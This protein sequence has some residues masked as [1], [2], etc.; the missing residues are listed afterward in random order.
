MSSSVVDIR[1]RLRTLEAEAKVCKNDRL[2]LSLSLGK[3]ETQLN[4]IAA[5]MKFGVALMGLAATAAP[6]IAWLLSRIR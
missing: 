3:I 5:L 2:D 6:G 4:T 1:S